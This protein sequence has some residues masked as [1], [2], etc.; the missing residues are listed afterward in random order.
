[1]GGTQSSSKM[2]EQ[3]KNLFEVLKGVVLRSSGSLSQLEIFLRDSLRLVPGK[4]TS[5][6]GLYVVRGGK[7]IEAKGMVPTF[8]NSEH[9]FIVRPLSKEFIRKTYEPTSLSTQRGIEAVYMVLSGILFLTTICMVS[10]LQDNSIDLKNIETGGPRKTTKNKEGDY[11]SKFNKLFGMYS[12][13]KGE[14]K[15]NKYVNNVLFAIRNYSEIRD[16]IVNNISKTYKKP[17]SKTTGDE[18]FVL[19]EEL[20]KSIDSFAICSRN[21]RTRVSGLLSILNKATANPG[22]IE[23]YINTILE[24]E[25]V[26]SWIKTKPEIHSKIGVMLGSLRRSIRLSSGSFEDIIHDIMTK[27]R[28]HI[29]EVCR[30][31]RLLKEYSG[32]SHKVLMYDK[33][34]KEYTYSRDAL[35]MIINIYKKFENET[36]KMQTDVLTAFYS[37][38]EN[39]NKPQDYTINIISSYNNTYLSLKKNVLTE[40]DPGVRIMNTF[41][42]ISNTYVKYLIKMN[43]ILSATITNKIIL[44]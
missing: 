25:F 10:P 11:E 44:R 32:S 6:S 19:H 38:F 27:M 20:L 22:M 4:D 12:S 2:K 39:N 3:E 15:Q 16:I 18:T 42:D 28:E 37:L 26:S 30:E 23:K 9:K 36:R 41:L 8:Q 29:E 7:D 43:E 40:K 21:H 31:N 34:K 14:P 1:M 24:G 17:Y 33:T 35:P 13:Q 5:K